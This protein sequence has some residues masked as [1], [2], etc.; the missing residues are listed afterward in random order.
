MLKTL[1]ISKLNKIF[2][3]GTLA[4]SSNTF[5]GELGNTKATVEEL[6]IPTAVK[7]MPTVAG[8][9]AARIDAFA[10]QI[11]KAKRYTVLTQLVL[12]HAPA[13]WNDAK[14]SFI[15]LGD[16]DDR[17]LYWSRLKMSRIL[18]SSEGFAKL[19]PNQ[20]Q[21]LLINQ[22]KRLTY[23]NLV[24]RLCIWFSFARPRTKN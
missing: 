20:Q 11:N 13:L 9:L 16:Y 6:R 24:R 12:R 21:K 19:F 8:R 18:R 15:T 4:L 10:E 3:V 14:K 17:P 2:L 1:K 7:A 22:V 5:A 23:L